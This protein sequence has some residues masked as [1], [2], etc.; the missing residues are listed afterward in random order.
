M[1]IFD[2]CDVA[3]RV[4][5]SPDVGIIESGVP[6]RPTPAH[7]R[8]DARTTR[9]V[10]RAFCREAQVLVARAFAIPADDLRQASRC[11]APVALARQA[12]MYLANVAGGVNLTQVGQGFGR[13]R[14]TVA[15]ACARIED[16][17]DDP[18][19]DLSLT[20]LE[21]AL[22]QSVRLPD[23]AA[24]RAG[25]PPASIHRQLHHEENSHDLEVRH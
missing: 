2:S 11:R 14:T 20:L 16:L 10:S 18:R 25:P 9:C 6:T 24:A 22:R 12:A 15:H 13:D 1:F 4:S 23:L 17:R 19:F 5:G 21:G 8:G 7:R 3:M